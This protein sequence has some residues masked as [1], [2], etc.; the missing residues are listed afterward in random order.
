MNQDQLLHLRILAVDDEPVNIALLQDLLSFSGFTQ[1]E[2][3]TNPREVVT[4]FR[5]HRPDLILLDLN[6]P[7]I[8]GF[9][10]MKVLEEEIDPS[11]YI[12]ILVLTAD[13]SVETK[14]RA[15]GVGA[16]DFLPKPF[17]MRRPRPFSTSG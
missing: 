7:F 13:I 2:S 14:R 8:D 1:I 9:G 16:T 10:V 3:T 17:V 15:L 6:M 4:L 12:P 11:E 5:A